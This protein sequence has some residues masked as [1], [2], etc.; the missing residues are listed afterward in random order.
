MRASVLVGVLWRGEEL[1]AGGG[2]AQKSETYRDVAGRVRYK[3]MSWRWFSPRGLGSQIM[4]EITGPRVFD[5]GAWRGRGLKSCI[6][7]K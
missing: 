6:Q 2:V 4:W 5:L 1:A 7:Q 3:F